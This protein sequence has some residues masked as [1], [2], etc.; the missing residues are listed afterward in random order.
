M[1]ENIFY[2]IESVTLENQ[3]CKVLG[4]ASCSNDA[5]L[6][7]TIDKPY[8]SY[9]IKTT[10]CQDL[11]NEF[12][13]DEELNTYSFELVFTCKKIRRL[14]IIFKNSNGNK[15]FT[16]NCS[17]LR[18]K[19][20]KSHFIFAM[21]NKNYAKVLYSIL[22]K[23]GFLKAKTFL[24]NYKF[25]TPLLNDQVKFSY[26]PLITIILRYENLDEEIL[27][28]VLSSIKNQSYDKYELFIISN[29]DFNKD[30]PIIEKYKFSYNLVRVGNN[31]FISA[32][33]D[34]I[35]KS[36]GDYI[37]FLND[38]DVLFTSFLSEYVTAINNNFD[39]NLFYSDEITKF[40]TIFLN[41]KLKPCFGW[42]TIR[43]HNYIGNSYLS[44]KSIIKEVGYLDMV[45][46]SACMYDL[47]LKIAEHVNN[48]LQNKFFNINKVLSYKMQTCNVSIEFDSD[49]HM[50]G[51][52][53]IVNHLSR[54]KIEATVLDGIVPKMYKVCYK[55]RNNPKI[56]IIIPNKD[57][58]ELLSN[59]L[60]SIYSKTSYNNFEI[61]IVENN[62]KEAEIF[63]Y[64]KKIEQ[65]YLNLKVIYYEGEFNYSKIN[66]YATSLATGDYLVF[67]NNDTE[68]I[69]PNWL[70]EMLMFCQH[71]HI[72]IVGAK[73]LYQ[74]NTIQH[75]GFLAN[76]FKLE[77]LLRYSKSDI[78]EVNFV[79]NLS[80]VTGACMMIRKKV[81][82]SIGMFDTCFKV[83]FNDTDLCF[84][85]RECGLDVV[86][87][88]S[89]EL[90][91]FESK[92]RG[93]N[94]TSLKK[95]LAAHELKMFIEKH[96]SLKTNDQFYKEEH[97]YFN[98][99]ML[100]QFMSSL[101]YNE[102]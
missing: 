84:R 95:S 88:P 23:D 38:N 66:N 82:L 10:L 43:S 102:P 85:V 70:E 19:N 39:I 21:Q 32:I 6:D 61:I 53:A 96:D 15:V 65:D 87:N 86:Y 17:K 57:K 12:N 18:H 91:H 47:V 50:S 28:R 36:N 73:L 40:G 29:A 33:N 93:K 13:L 30:L 35:K 59:C 58:Y 68:V 54:L 56:T 52:M 90:Y 51:K 20:L 55:I 71:E 74:D 75:A 100:E 9:N 78:A 8:I 48:K 60:S 94:D 80:V 46:G 64:Y 5:N 101:E 26:N 34:S 11:A 7:I 62:S 42:E 2:K 69:A 3:V 1:L 41:A 37:L 72:G 81:F 14:K 77:H 83:A 67:L 76:I 25:Q 4:L 98:K 31:N 24:S 27:A 79:R 63:D 45:L 89:V 16:I 97:F 44:K 49:L 22:K 99:V 92:T